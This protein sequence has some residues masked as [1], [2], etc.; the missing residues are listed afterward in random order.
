MVRLFVNNLPVEVPLNSTVLAAC[1]SIGIEVPRFCY[2]ERLS[3]AGNCRSCLVEVFKAPKPVVACATPVMNGMHVFTD[4]PLVKKAREGVF[5][6]LLKN[7]PLDCPICDQGGECDLQDQ[8]FYFGGDLSRFF[9]TKRS[10]EDKNVGPLIRTIM[11]RC[12]HCTRCVR[13]ATDVAGI[14]SFGTTNRG[15]TTE[16]SSYV[17]RL[18]DSEMS[19][20]VIDLCP[21]GALTSKPYSFVARPWELFQEDSIDL[22]D[23]LGSN[24]SVSHRFGEVKRVGPRINDNLNGEWISDKARFAFDGLLSSARNNSVSNL[25]TS[26]IQEVEETSLQTL[27]LFLAASKV[28]GK[29]KNVNFILNE[30]I[31][32]ESLFIYKSFAQQLSANFVSLSQTILKDFS[33]NQGLN[34]SLVST[35]TSD[36]CI[37][38]GFEPRSEAVILNSLIREGIV[39]GTITEVHKIGAPSSLPVYRSS[40]SG[41]TTASLKDLKSGLSSLSLKL[42]KSKNPKVIF[43][44]LLDK[45][46]HKNSLFSLLEELNVNLQSLSFVNLLPEKANSYGL[47][48]LNSTS[49]KFL[50]LKKS[51]LNVLIGFDKKDTSSFIEKSQLQG[52]FYNISPDFNLDKGVG[53]L[54]MAVNVE[55]AGTFVNAEGRLQKSSKFNSPEI[56]SLFDS[57]LKTLA[58]LLS[59]IKI[60]KDNKRFNT[61]SL[62]LNVPVYNSLNKGPNNVDQK[63]SVFKKNSQNKIFNSSFKSFISDFYRTDFVSRNSKTMLSSSIA[64]RR[65]SSNFFNSI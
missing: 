44:P 32:L 60:L 29:K 35:K 38:V 40:H 55:R 27:F 64:R 41:L 49:K 39:S 56:S 37:L 30:N 43:G 8:S 31:D 33:R 51:Q 2:H 45:S 63:F 15:E 25:K 13:F 14:E 4:T 24:L 22:S 34:N 50:N 48:N 18:F 12:I 7:H 65:N 28:K 26:P 61:L 53:S 19:G 59:S 5:E 23:S 17:E 3:V 52:C 9:E 1:E 16:I 46:I 47:V 58:F 11:T 42:A 57:E 10:V 20:N 6:F 62:S 21:V 36:L 54:M